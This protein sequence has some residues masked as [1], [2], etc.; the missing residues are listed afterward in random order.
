MNF[1]PGDIRTWYLWNPT[2]VILTAD[3]QC[4]LQKSLTSGFLDTCNQIAPAMH[5]LFLWIQNNKFGWKKKKPSLYCYH[6][7]PNNA[8][9]IEKLILLILHKSPGIC[10]TFP[11]QYGSISSKAPS[12]KILP[13]T[14]NYFSI[15]PELRRYK[16]IW[17]S[18][19]HISRTDC[20]IPLDL[21]ILLTSV[22]IVIL[23][24][25]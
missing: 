12:P 18:I 22:L 7:D 10:Y 16:T 11:D 15:K 6:R 19:S 23:K 24:L 3:I 17:I 8:P 14:V 5:S 21:L 4:Q 2:H 9:A 20:G 25:K 13:R 1:K